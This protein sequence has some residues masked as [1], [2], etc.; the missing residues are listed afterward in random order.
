[1]N[2]LE[3]FIE[4]QKLRQDH[5][6]VTV[7][8]QMDIP[9]T[10]K[11]VIAP[12]ILMPFVENAFKHVSRHRNGSNWIT[13]KLRLDRD[14]LR[15]EV[16]NSASSLQSSSSEFIRHRGIGLK[17]VQRRLD[18]LY[19]GK[20]TL[21]KENGDDQFRIALTLSLHERAMAEPASLTEQ[22]ATIDNFIHL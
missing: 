10:G 2:Y 15:L 21:V 17:N 20:Y 4:L 7:D 14:M 19:P 6:H 13:M 16:S 18:L 5:S 11:L 1:M 9:H 3:N 12:F 8:I 22:N